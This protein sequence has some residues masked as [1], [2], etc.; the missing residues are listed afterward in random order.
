MKKYG[1]TGWFGESHRHYLASKGVKT[2]SK[3]D[4]KYRAEKDW[5]YGDNSSIHMHKGFEI[6]IVP[7]ARGFD[8]WIRKNGEQEDDIQNANSK[9]E[10]LSAA[11]SMINGIKATEADTRK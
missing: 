10:A 6:E 9:E 4:W 11:K 3:H 7:H 1:R 8:A 2:A 5:T